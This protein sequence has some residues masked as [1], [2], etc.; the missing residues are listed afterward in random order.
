LDLFQIPACEKILA[1][2]F[3]NYA[4]YRPDPGRFEPKDINATLCTHIIYG[5]AQIKG[6]V[7]LATENDERNLKFYFIYKRI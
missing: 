6:S 7:A 5:F 1:C 4:Q 2:Y 3:T